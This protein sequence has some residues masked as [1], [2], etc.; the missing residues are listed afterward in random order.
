MKVK[1]WDRKRLKPWK[2]SHINKEATLA[3][4]PTIHAAIWPNCR[5][6]RQ[7]KETAREKPR[8]DASDY[9][10][11]LFRPQK[12]PIYWKIELICV[13]WGLYE[14]S[15]HEN[16]GFRHEVRLDSQMV[17]AEASASLTAHKPS[18]GF[19]GTSK[20]LSVSNRN[21]KEKQRRW[22]SMCETLFRSYWA[23]SK[24]TQKLGPPCA[25]AIFTFE[26]SI[27]VKPTA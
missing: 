11:L 8:I 3:M 6:V 9:Q 1:I 20:A 12:P 17:P 25:S 16:G 7:Q 22:E 19:S 14:C 13:S 27:S 4:N 24:T 10:F 5:V 18:H 23:A 15:D 26:T 2:H 21:G